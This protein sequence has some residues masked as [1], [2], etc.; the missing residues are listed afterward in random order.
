[1]DNLPVFPGRI[2]FDHLPKTAGMATNRWLTGELGQACVSP[3]L[4]GAHSLL[5]RAYGGA[6]SVV[7][8]H[9]HFDGEG[10]DP[11]YRYATCVREPIDRALSWIFYVLNNFS[12]VELSG[13]WKEVE[14]FV[15]SEG[16]Q[17]GGALLPHICNPYVE[18]FC[19][20]FD[21]GVQTDEGKI[22]SSLASIEKY[23]VIGFYDDMP[24]FLRELAALVEVPSPVRLE[25]VNVTNERPD[26]VSLSPKFLRRLSELNSLDIAFCERLMEIRQRRDTQRPVLLGLTKPKWKKY[27]LPR[28]RS[29]SASEFLLTSFRQNGSHFTRGQMLQFD[30][31]FSVEQTF[32]DI[33]VGIQLFDAAQQWAFGTNSGLLG[34]R[35]KNAGAGR[36]R[37]RYYLASDLPD[38]TYSAG[39]SFVGKSG[40]VVAQLA[41][42]DC[43]STFHVSSPRIIAGVGYASLP[44]DFSIRKTDDEPVHLIRHG[45]GHLEYDSVPAEVTCNCIFEVSA[46]LHN[47]SDQNWTNVDR[48]AINV[49]YHWLDQ[50]GRVI[51]FDGLRSPIE[52]VRLRSGASTDVRVRVLAPPAPGLYH[53]SILPVQEANQWLDDCGFT[54][55]TVGISVI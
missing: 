25:K 3:N 12:S 43:L 53:L 36:Y 2:V 51:V 42:H 52:T 46:K 37:A 1:M 29:W 31:E 22:A 35:L 54:V 49:S 26:V 15:K 40:D 44:A 45:D 34:T 39:F 55:S 38:G 17:V 41:W 23:D 27:D 6:Y 8:G 10:L 16:E 32:A 24:G 33:E 19:R 4:V 18:H 9:L 7:S 5:V 48:F 13:L 50:E 20:I 47:S 11:R 30:L 14:A 21:A 28:D